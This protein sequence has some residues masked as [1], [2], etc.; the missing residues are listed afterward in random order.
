MVLD[1][2]FYLLLGAWGMTRWI[3]SLHENEMQFALWTF[4]KPVWAEHSL[5]VMEIEHIQTLLQHNKIYISN[6][7]GIMKHERFMSWVRIFKLKGV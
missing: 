6:V 3:S 5:R 4:D 7:H 2:A 1:Y